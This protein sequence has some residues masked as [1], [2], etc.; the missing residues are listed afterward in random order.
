MQIGTAFLFDRASRQMTGL[1]ASAARLQ[2]EIATGKR[3]QTPS[4]DPVAAGRVARLERLDADD[5][6]Y[7]D[8][9]K[10]ATSILGQ[11]DRALESVETQLQRASELAIAAA[12]E[13][14]NDGNRAAIAAEL[15]AI[16]DDLFRLANS[17][18]IRGA[19]LFGGSAGAAFARAAD[20]SIQFVGT[21]EASPIPI[22]ESATV[23]VNDNGQRLFGNLPAGAGTTDV[24][25]VV[26]DLAAAIEPGGSP[27]P[28]TRQA[29]VQ[30]SIAGIAAASSQIVTGRASI[31]ARAARIEIETERLTRARSENEIE[32]G[33]LEGVNVEA[34]IT[35]LQKTMVTLQAAQASFARLTQLSVF[36]YIR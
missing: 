29:S 18:D 16:V 27:D 26:A 35:E 14:L 34:A 5:S 7:L 10:L 3:I 24:F 17:T 13:T 23:I 6:R 11:S 19:P 30:A 22:G 8:N 12:N 33:S 2:V 32:R 20:G 4:D 36:D 15:R 31:G 25:A 1:S 9:L 21:G 28:A